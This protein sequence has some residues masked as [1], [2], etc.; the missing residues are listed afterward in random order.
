MLLKWSTLDSDEEKCKTY[1][2]NLCHEL[3][4]FLYMK[5]RAFFDKVVRQ[6]IECKLE[7]TFVDLFLLARYEELV[8]KY[9]GLETMNKTNGFEKCLLVDA[10]VKLGK[11]DD[12]KKLVDYIKLVKEST[13]YTSLEQDNKV[14]DIVLNLNM[15][16]KGPGGAGVT[17]SSTTNSI[18]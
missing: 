6:L 2:K 10:L 14:F 13:T 8:K 7:K 1:Y 5:D 11:K 12:A 4:V 15:L 9:W 16:K 3:N 17:F 18:G